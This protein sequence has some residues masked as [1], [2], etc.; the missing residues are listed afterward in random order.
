MPCHLFRKKREPAEWAAMVIET[1]GRDL[2]DDILQ[3]SQMFFK[4]NPEN[5]EKVL[6]YL[7]QLESSYG[8]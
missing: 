3:K 2:Y 1:I 4:V 6:R 8:A 7:E 5:M